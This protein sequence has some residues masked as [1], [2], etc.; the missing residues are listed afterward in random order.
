MSMPESVNIT[1]P[2][3]AHV[4]KAIMWKSLNGMLDPEAKA[5]LL[6]GSLFM[7]LCDNCKHSFSLN[8]PILYNDMVNNVMIYYVLSEKDVPEVEAVLVETEGMKVE[9]GAGNFKPQY[10]IVTSQNALREKAIVFE[11]QLDDRLV[12]IMKLLYRAQLMKK[13]PDAEITEIFFFA[14]EGNFFFEVI[15]NIP[16]TMKFNVELYS[17]LQKDAEHLLKDT[18]NDHEVDALWAERVLHDSEME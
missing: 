14:E 16:T 7:Y 13:F 1:C 3:C 5:Q 4:G 18:Q 17:A 2:Q 8:Y 6:D 15:G 9:L 11:Q 10:R 12:E